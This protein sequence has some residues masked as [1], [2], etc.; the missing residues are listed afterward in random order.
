MRQKAQETRYQRVERLK[1]QNKLQLRIY[2]IVRAQ[3]LD[4]KML[5]KLLPKAR[6]MIPL[7]ATCT[8]LIDGSLIHANL[9]LNLTDFYFY[10]SNWLNACNQ[11]GGKYMRD[12]GVLFYN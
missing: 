3:F 7:I 10:K 2:K 4:K 6:Q 12:L 11:A 9:G 1:R 5:E 8:V